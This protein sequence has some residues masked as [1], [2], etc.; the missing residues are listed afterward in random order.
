MIDMV[1]G[2]IYRH[3]LINDKGIEKSYIGQTVNSVN[4]RWQKNGRGYLVNGKGEK[5]DSKF[6]NAINKYG[7][8]NFHHDIVEVVECETK[9]ELK[10]VLNFLEKA[11]IEVYESF[12]N[13]YNSTTG[14]D[15]CNLSEETK[16]KIT[17]AV[18][19]DVVCLNTGEIFHGILLAYQWA[20]GNNDKNITKICRVCKGKDKSAYKHPETGE[21]LV[22]AYKNDYDKMTKEEIKERLSE[23]NVEDMID[24]DTLNVSYEQDMFKT[25][26]EDNLNPIYSILS[27]AQ[28]YVFNEHILNGETMEIVA[29]RHNVTTTRIGNLKKQVIAKITNTYSVNEFINLIK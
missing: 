13:G 19:Q 17:N 11:Y 10:D 1:K 26:L 18:R 21:K 3:W 2:Y 5:I 12:T 20:T 28:T 27:P 16:N 7:W 23:V 9:E 4:V 6:A 25:T 14:G 8:N 29:K 24:Y 15:S 22:W